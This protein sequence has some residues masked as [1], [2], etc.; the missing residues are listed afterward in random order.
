M[1][2]RRRSRKTGSTTSGK[3]CP[4]CEQFLPLEDFSPRHN[5]TEDE[6]LKPED[7]GFRQSRCMKCNGVYSR[8]RSLF[9]RM[10]KEAGKV[11]IE[12][13]S[14][15][16]YRHLVV[17]KRC[18][19]GLFLDLQQMVDE[20]NEGLPPERCDLELHGVRVTRQPVLRQQTFEFG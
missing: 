20:F 16:V 8:R 19:E 7:E 10:R 13:A 17:G 1:A 2:Q 6:P 12:V 4:E 14:R 3:R 18:S 5:P 11:A 9:K 15:S